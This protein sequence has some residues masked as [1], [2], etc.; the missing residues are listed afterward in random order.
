MPNAFAAVILFVLPLLAFVCGVGVGLAIAKGQ[1]QR[2]AFLTVAGFT[3]AL[4]DLA[5]MIWVASHDNPMV[6]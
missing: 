5:L 2:A 3:L 1:V 4:G 6:P